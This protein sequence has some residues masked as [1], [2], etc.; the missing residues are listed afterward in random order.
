MN[1]LSL[2]YF[3]KLRR[4]PYTNFE[5]IIPEVSEESEEN[6][7]LQYINKVYRLVFL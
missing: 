6:F 3:E 7:L 1:K 5:N 4:C 2:K